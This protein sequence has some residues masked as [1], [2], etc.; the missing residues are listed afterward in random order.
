M[1]GD[2]N[3]AKKIMMACE[4]KLSLLEDEGTIMTELIHFSPLIQVIQHEQSKT[5]WKSRSGN[6]AVPDKLRDMVKFVLDVL[7]RSP[8]DRVPDVPTESPV[9][10]KLETFPSKAVV[11]RMPQFK[12]DIVNWENRKAKKG[13]MGA[14]SEYSPNDLKETEKSEFEEDNIACKNDHTTTQK[15]TPGLFVL[16]CIHRMIWGNLKDKYFIVKSLYYKYK[17]LQGQLLRN[18][19]R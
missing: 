3:K 19:T 13:G 8:K 10:R 7:N 17:L 12:Q 16:S 15:T 2:I 1:R 18:I 6:L 9:I 4:G 11:R 5:Q 14:T